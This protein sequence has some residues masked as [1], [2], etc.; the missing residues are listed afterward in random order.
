MQR[1]QE[2]EPATAE[3]LPGAQAAQAALPG[4]LLPPAAQGVHTAA[5]GAPL[6]VPA[7]QGTQAPLPSC[8]C[9]VPGGHGVQAAA[10]GGLKEPAEHARHWSA[11]MPAA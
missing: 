6:N 2:G 4:T 7:A 5:P 3:N 10:P 11:P 1:E 8:D 9:E